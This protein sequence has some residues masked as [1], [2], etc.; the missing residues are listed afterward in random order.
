M[1]FERLWWVKTLLFIFAFMIL[2]SVVP[3]QGLHGLDKI[4]DVYEVHARGGVTTCVVF[5]I[6]VLAILFVTQWSKE[7]CGVCKAPKK[8]KK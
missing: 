1:T 5:V 3:F 6:I 7:R 2:W 4:M 8:S